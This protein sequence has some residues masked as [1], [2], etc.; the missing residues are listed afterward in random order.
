MASDAE[1]TGCTAQ[2]CH[3]DGMAELKERLR[4]DLTAAMKGRDELRS[5]TLRMALTAVTNAE[6]AGKEARQLSDEQVVDVLATEAKKRR[7][8]AA[9]YDKAKRADLADKERNEARILAD[10]LPAPLSSD[11]IAELVKDTIERLGVAG[12]AKAMGAVMGALQAATRGRADGGL[13]AAEVRRQL[14]G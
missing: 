1:A 5:S 4:A 2:G 11:E 13:V 3:T 12:D 10:Y 7:E 14:Q 6:V 8:A 9:A